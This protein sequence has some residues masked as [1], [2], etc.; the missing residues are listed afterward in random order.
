MRRCPNLVL[1]SINIRLI[2]DA[3]PDLDQRVSCSNAATPI[4]GTAAPQERVV[5][6]IDNDGRFA[7]A[8]VVVVANGGKY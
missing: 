6:D 8:D 2:R 4:R 1:K 5:G 7:V 3:H